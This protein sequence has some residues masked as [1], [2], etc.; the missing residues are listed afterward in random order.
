MESIVEP[1]DWLVSDR[2]L[3]ISL[4]SPLLVLYTFSFYKY[5]REHDILQIEWNKFE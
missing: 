2:E 5:K 3:Y 4:V 1:S